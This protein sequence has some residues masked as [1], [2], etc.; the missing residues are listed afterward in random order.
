VQCPVQCPIKGWAEGSSKAK[1]QA[2]GVTKRD[3]VKTISQNAL[4]RR[5]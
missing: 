1:Q 4:T 5:C 2:N 3:E